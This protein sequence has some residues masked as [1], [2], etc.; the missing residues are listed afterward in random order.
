MS[1]CIKS[2]RFVNNVEGFDFFQG[3][4]HD[5]AFLE[6]DTPYGIIV[7]YTPHDYEGN[8]TLDTRVEDDVT[9][10]IISGD[11]QGRSRRSL[12]S[13]VWHYGD[14]VRVLYVGGSTTFHP[15]QK[16]APYGLTLFCGRKNATRAWF[17]KDYMAQV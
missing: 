15:P 16:S 12:Q 2:F 17:S 14:V 7:D 11:E 10:V 6:I 3:D 9:L 1:D 5:D 8:V 13:L 4:P